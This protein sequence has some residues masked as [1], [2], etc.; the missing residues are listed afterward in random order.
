MDYRYDF[1]EPDV[2]DICE[3]FKNWLY[4]VTIFVTPMLMSKSTIAK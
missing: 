2:C 4:I 1:K 3:H